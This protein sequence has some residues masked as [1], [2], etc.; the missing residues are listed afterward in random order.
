MVSIS[1][2]LCDNMRII[3]MVERSTNMVLVRKY[4]IRY[5]MINQIFN[6]IDIVERRSNTK[7]QTI[8]STFQGEFV[9]I[10]KEL[11]DGGY[12]I[13]KTWPLNDGGDRYN[14]SLR[15]FLTR[16]QQAIIRQEQEEFYLPKYANYV[17]M[18]IIHLANNT[19]VDEL[20][21]SMKFYGY[22]DIRKLID[23][24]CKVE[25]KLK[26]GEIKIGQFFGYCEER[27]EYYV[28]VNNK[29]FQVQYVKEI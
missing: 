11:L 28:N 22:I 4:I 25:C 21:S 5:S 6:L 29:V 2:E 18:Y 15:T 8:K 9:D 23:F 13:I 1:Y 17:K 19:L 10:Q 20:T 26:N 16:R 14:I 12:Q 7:I 3:I 27:L 24:N